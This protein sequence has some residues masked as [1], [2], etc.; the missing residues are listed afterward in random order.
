MRMSSKQSQ[1]AHFLDLCD[2]VEI[3]S[4]IIKDK[5]RDEVD[6]SCFQA[7]MNQHYPCLEQF[8]RDMKQETSHVISIKASFSEVSATFDVTY[9]NNEVKPFSYDNIDPMNY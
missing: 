6:E 4:D 7:L 3:L 8:F 9:E 2:R 5:D 1:I